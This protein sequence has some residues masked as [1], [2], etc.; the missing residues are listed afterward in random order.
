MRDHPCIEHDQGSKCTNKGEAKKRGFCEK[1]LSSKFDD[2]KD[3][4][5]DVKKSS[6]DEEDHGHVDKLFPPHFDRNPGHVD[7]PFRLDKA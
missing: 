4:D 7:L 2:K 3:P 1:L 6:G 5:T